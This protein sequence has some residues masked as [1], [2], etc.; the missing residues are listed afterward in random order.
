MKTL[1]LR[2][3]EK[4][5][6]LVLDVS[7]SLP[8]FV[9]GDPGRLRQV[10][11]NLTGNA[12]KFT[13]Y[14]EIVIRVG[15]G[16]GP[17]QVL[18]Q[19]S[20]T[21]IGIAE[22]K[23]AHVFEA[24]TQED[25]S[26]TRRFGGTGLGLTISNRLVT[27]MG[28]SLKVESRIGVG[29]TFSFELPL[30]EDTG[31]EDRAEAVV[32]LSGLCVLL[33]DDNET[34]R[35]VLSRLF[36]GWGM[37]VTALA[38]ASEVLASLDG[39]QPQLIVLDAHMPE[40]DGF[41]LAARLRED[42]R[43]AGVPKM[44]LSSGAVRGDAERCRDLGIAAY[45]PKPVGQQELLAGIH[46]VLGIASAEVLSTPPLVTRHSLRDV[47]QPLTVLLVEDHPVNQKL[48][49]SLLEKWGHSV[50]LA[51]NGQEALD[52]VAKARF[53]VILMDLQ[54]PVMGG[55]EATQRLRMGGCRTRI[56]AMTAN[57]MEGDR[58]LC[59]EGGMD[60]YIAK[61]IKAD[62]LYALLHQRESSPAEANDD[63]VAARSPVFDYVAALAGADS[64]IVDVVAPLFVESSTD[65]IA[66]L[67][68][69]LEQGSVASAHRL[70]HTLRGL[71]GTFAAVPVV[72]AARRIEEALGR[73][74]LATA[75]M[76]LPELE[77]ELLK[78]VAVL[79]DC[80]QVR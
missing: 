65:D 13:E 2:A 68:R 69:E 23:L 78:L 58:E 50:T 51:V 14:G 77:A 34:N 3:Y 29:S 1:S 26:T 67:R 17:G 37:R 41:M 38:S 72:M 4:G 66:F 19:V 54:M 64:E 71:A 60:D 79:R 80:G 24:F 55:L 61:P 49:I 39:M 9:F 15:E 28:G 11:L 33:V 74:D 27:M 47:Q 8:Q 6:E 40:I 10:L 52:Q 42:S 56:V 76:T 18:C 30:P 45:F 12:I 44:M 48:A 75:R 21:G 36:S 25:S 5:L 63:K 70:V 35:I 62:E 43:T 73:N 16:G 32:D 31:R 46:S 57:A 59:L 22:D 53:D 20:D 7:P